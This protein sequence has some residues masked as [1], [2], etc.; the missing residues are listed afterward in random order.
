MSLESILEKILEDAQAEAQRILEDARVK[1]DA[2][3]AEAEREA[4]EQ[5]QELLD[6]AKRQAELEASRLITQARLEGR[7][8]LLS[9]KKAAIAEVLERSFR[10]ENLSSKTLK[11]KLVLKDGER[12]VPFDQER[13]KQDIGPLLE[14][15][16]AEVL[17]L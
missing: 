9:E 3:Q 10:E 15:E 1:A 13:L 17:D 2:I 8:R 16:I 11:Q 12:E 5:A 7:I 14:R 4:R 6:E